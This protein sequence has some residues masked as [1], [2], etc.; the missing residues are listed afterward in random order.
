[1]VLAMF[2]DADHAALLPALAS[3]RL[4]VTPSVI[5]PAEA[6]PFSQTPQAEFARGAFSLQERQGHPLAAARFH[7]RTAFYLDVGHAWTPAVPSLAELLI[8][9]TIASPAT[10]EAAEASDPA[11]RVKRIG[12]GE[13]E[14]AAVAITRGWTLWSD[15]AAIIN[16]LAALHPGHPVERISDLVVRAAREELLGCDE[17]AALYNEVFRDTL[18]LWT[19]RTLACENDDVIVR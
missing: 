6:P 14:T 7:R 1:M 13:A 12:R 11:R 9:E 5:N 19:T 15:D 2:V 10:W 8:Q 4:F 3:G 16:L 18:G 17:A